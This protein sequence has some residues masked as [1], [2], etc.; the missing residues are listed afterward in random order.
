MST[1]RMVKKDF[2]M[3]SKRER[4]EFVG[5]KRLIRGDSTLGPKLIFS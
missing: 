3:I 1:C 4:L 2:N 5:L